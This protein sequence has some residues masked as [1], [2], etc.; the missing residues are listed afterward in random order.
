MTKSR[1]SKWKIITSIFFISLFLSIV[2]VATDRTAAY[3]APY[4]RFW[5]M[6]AGVLLALFAAKKIEH[7]S[8]PFLPFAGLT[9]IIVAVFM[10]TT[11]TPFPGVAAVVP[12]LGTVLILSGNRE[13]WLNRRFLAT[14][15]PVF[16]GKI[17]Y[18]LYLWH[19]PMLILPALILN[20]SLDSYEKIASL[21]CSL[22]LALLTYIFVEK[23]IRF[24]AFTRN[25][26][27]VLAVVLSIITSG[28]LIIYAFG[29]LGSRPL[30]TTQGVDPRLTQIPDFE[31]QKYT[32][33]GTCHITD[34]AIVTRP[35]ECYSRLSDKNIAL[36]GDSHAAS[37]YPGLIKVAGSHGW[38]VNQLTTS[39]CPAILEV[40]SN[41]HPACRLANQ[42]VLEQLSILQPSILII[43]SSWA[44]DNHPMSSIEVYKK[45]KAT[46]EIVKA[47]IPQTK[48]FILGSL[49]TW[50]N[51]PQ[52]AAFSYMKTH[53]GSWESMPKQLSADTHSNF[54]KA[55]NQ[56]STEMNIEF[57][58]ISETICSE[59]LCTYKVGEK[60][61]DFIA[62]DQEHLSKSGSEYLI[63]K[64]FSKRFKDISMKNEGLR[65]IPN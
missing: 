16:I 55:I 48:I 30:S 23:P 3:F 56:A 60:I 13:N 57:I 65:P 46:L 24:G 4:S 35:E 38:G 43:E 7:T 17:S 50:I 37:L 47:R 20:R 31:Y 54:D 53:G 11:A 62:I 2:L 41:Y 14:K 27:V 32:Q 8:Y 5:E 61:T 18:P 40:D 51:S 58:S 12:V 6:L 19:W 22:T 9:M 1:F 52:A 10:Y 63:D 28:S 59:S 39:G 64:L 29:D 33:A 34:V 15:I 44:G 36:W 25:K 49:P 21:F 26:P 45:L 42:E